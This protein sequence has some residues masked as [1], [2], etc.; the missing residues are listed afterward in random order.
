MYPVLRH[1]L[2]TMIALLF[3]HLVLVSEPGAT[4]DYGRTCRQAGFVQ[5]D[6]MS[7]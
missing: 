6:L 3:Q 4:N 2:A 5:R 7:V 1:D